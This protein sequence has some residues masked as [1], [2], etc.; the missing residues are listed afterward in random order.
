MM[1][2]SARPDDA[3]HCAAILNDWID[4]TPWMPR[5]H[6]HADVVRHY[7]ETVFAKRD[8][9]VIGDPPQGYLAT[10][11][12]DGFV[13]SFYVARS[14]RNQGLGATLMTDAQ[15][16]FDDL[17]LWTFQVNTDARRFY[18]AHGFAEVDE[19]DGDNE[20]GLPDVLLHWQRGAA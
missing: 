4:E 15:D 8:I 9:R 19:T 6:S 2:R 3:P 11:T 16:R 1:P 12:A 7:R 20:E 18:A 10:D 13:T 5:V 17:R 14:S